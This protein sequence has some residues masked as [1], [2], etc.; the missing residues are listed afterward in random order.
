MFMTGICHPRAMRRTAQ[1][2]GARARV[3]VW[4]LV[5]LMLLVTLA[6]AISRARQHGAPPGERGWVE[7]CT[8]HGMVWVKPDADA[9]NPRMQWATAHAALL[10]QLDACDLCTLGIDRST[11]P[12][13]FSG[14]GLGLPLPSTVPALAGMGP[15]RP[16]QV[17]LRARGPP[18]RN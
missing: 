7:V 5:S 11:T 17:A 10:Q 2:A 9:L 4:M 8:A 1:G 3:W 12:P 18:E 15:V 16:V 6:P 13:D 14:W